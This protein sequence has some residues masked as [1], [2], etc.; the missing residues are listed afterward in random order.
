[1]NRREFLKFGATAAVAASVGLGTAGKIVASAAESKGPVPSPVYRTLGRTGLKVTVVSFG[2]MLTPEPEVIRAAFEGGIN[3]VDTARRYMGGRNEEIVARA[4][5]GYRKNLYVATKTL[6]SS[7]SRKEIFSDVETSLATLQI[8]H[9]DVI[10]LHSLSSRERVFVPEVREALKDLRKQGKVRF[11]GVTTHINQAEVVN[12]LVDDP[13]KFF[14]TA[15]VAY[16]FKSPPEIGTAIA[17]AAEAGIGIIAMKTQAGG[18]KTEELGEV[19]PH[20]AALKWVLQN[21]HVACAIP[22]MRDM[23]MLLDDAAVMGMK[24]TARDRQTLEQYSRA[25]DN[26]Y[27]RL[28][29][30]CLPTC[31]QGVAIPD[32]NRALMYAR[33]YGDERLARSAYGEIPRRQ[34]ASTCQGCS[35]CIALCVHHLDIAQRVLD[36]RR[37]FA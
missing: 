5:K 20:Q 10:Q 12:A 29:G 15:L 13:E 37:L 34:S 2:A 14:D 18:Y 30:E 4:L 3:Y 6:A 22:G 33:A 26:E 31:P 11:F 16:N 28:C 1:M 21:R 25:I 23:G 19:S 17:R 32:I 36:A 8:D 24:M 7:N 35:T 27:C 9:I